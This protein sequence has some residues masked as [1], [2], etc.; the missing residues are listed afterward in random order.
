[1]SN[2]DA[3]T[4][5]LLTSEHFVCST[6]GRLT[7]PSVHQGD[8]GAAGEVRLHGAQLQADRRPEGLLLGDGGR[9]R[10]VPGRAAAPQDDRHQEGSGRRSG[11][12]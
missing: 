3:L 9:R 10:H 4:L 6:I 2:M 1:M 8:E 5:M 12:P 7:F 11:G